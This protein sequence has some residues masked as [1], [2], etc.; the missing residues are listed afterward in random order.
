MGGKNVEKCEPLA[1]YMLVMVLGHGVHIGIL[2]F[3]IMPI[4]PQFGHW[5]YYHTIIM[6]YLAATLCYSI[7]KKTFNLGL[8]SSTR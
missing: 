4:E 8:L 1:I 5:T 3:L 7:L 6:V 2:E